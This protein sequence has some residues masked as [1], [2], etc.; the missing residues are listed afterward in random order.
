MA[1]ELTLR[2]QC[3]AALRALVVQYPNLGTPAAQA[4]LDAYLCHQ[5]ASQGED[6]M[7]PKDYRT[8][9]EDLVNVALR[10][11]ASVIP[12]I[13]AHV[14]TLRGANRWAKVGRSDALRDL[15][16]RGLGSLATPP[17]TQAPARR[18]KEPL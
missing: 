5:R 15:V 17:V 1:D 12:V 13:D 7:P 18:R 10:L 4:R 2:R 6:S 3:L 14:E 16:L 9:G 8:L 11:P